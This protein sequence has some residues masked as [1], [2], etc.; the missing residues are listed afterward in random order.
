M[1]NK[2][3]K[4]ITRFKNSIR[5]AYWGFKNPDTL[6]E[7]NF[8]MLSDLLRMILKVAKEDRH[9]MTHIAFIHPEDN[10]EHQIVSIWAGAGAGAEPTKRIKELL[11]ENAVLK[12]QLSRNI[13]NELN[14]KIQE[15]K[16]ENEALNVQ[17]TQLRS[18]KDEQ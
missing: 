17:L 12:S 2:L 18:N 16:I 13:D 9:M 11:N 6:R 15:L 8:K 10:T 3:K 5:L 4:L 7:G 14:R 1:K